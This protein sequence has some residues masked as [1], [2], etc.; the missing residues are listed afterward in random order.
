MPNAY[1]EHISRLKELFKENF[2][3]N[4][5]KYAKSEE[6]RQLSMLNDLLK[7][8]KE[9]PFEANAI[10][11]DMLPDNVNDPQADSEVL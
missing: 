1:Q 8:G 7:T 3:A 5:K 11:G 2:R 9:E 4:Y 10:P 6:L